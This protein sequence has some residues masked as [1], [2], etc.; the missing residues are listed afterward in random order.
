MVKQDAF[1]VDAARSHL[2]WGKVSQQADFYAFNSSTRSNRLLQ[3]LR[4]HR[5]CNFDVLTAHSPLGVAIA[6]DEK[7]K[8]G[9]PVTRRS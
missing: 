9:P 5:H 3:A 6:G 7:S 2:Q 1:E 4:T 8:S